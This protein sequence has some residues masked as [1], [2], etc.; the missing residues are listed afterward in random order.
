LIRIGSL[1]VTYPHLTEIE[2][3]NATRELL[4]SKKKSEELLRRDIKLLSLPYGSYDNEILELSKKAGY[5][6]VFLNIPVAPS[7]GNNN[8]LIGRM[9]VS[10]NAWRIEYRLKM[11][12]AYS[13]LA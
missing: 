1:C 10:L 11:M 2:K 7:P 5:E 6:H 4:D 13:W 9:D 12:G 8:Y 3:H